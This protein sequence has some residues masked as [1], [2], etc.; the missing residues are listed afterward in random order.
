MS[1]ESDF[2]PQLLL[3]VFAPSLRRDIDP[4]NH[5]IG[6]RKLSRDCVNLFGHSSLRLV[7]SRT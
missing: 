1:N 6:A 7:E 4:D 5:C 3:R 2:N